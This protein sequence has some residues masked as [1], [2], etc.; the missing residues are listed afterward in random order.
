MTQI[1]RKGTILQK[2]KREKNLFI[3]R[4]AF[5]RKFVELNQLINNKCISL[6]KTEHCYRFILLYFIVF[7]IYYLT[8]ISSLLSYSLECFWW[9]FYVVSSCVVLTRYHLHANKSGIFTPNTSQNVIVVQL[10]F[11]VFN[12]PNDARLAAVKCMNPVT[13]LNSCYC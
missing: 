11:K 13:T 4:L 9:K 8:I 2:W 5:L 7:V 10:H 6:L 1:S 3:W 12:I